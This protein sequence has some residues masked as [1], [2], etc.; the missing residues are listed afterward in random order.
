MGLAVAKDEGR[1]CWACA[2]A[3]KKQGG[4]SLSLKVKEWCQNFNHALDRCLITELTNSYLS[5]AKSFAF[6]GSQFLSDYGADLREEAKT[7]VSY[8]LHMENFPP[9]LKTELTQS[10]TIYTSVPGPSSFPQGAASLYESCPEFC[11]YLIVDMLKATINRTMGNGNEAFDEKVIIFYR[12]VQIFIPRAAEVVYA[13]IRGPDQCWVQRLN[14]SEVQDCIFDVTHDMLLAR[15]KKAA[16]A[17]TVGPGAPV[18]FYLAIDATKVEKVL[19]MSASQRAIIGGTLPNHVFNISDLPKDGVKAVISGTS[20]SV[21]INKAAEVKV[22]VISFQSTAADVPPSF[23]VSGRPQG[24]NETSN[25]VQKLNAA[26]IEVGYNKPSYTN[27][28]VDGASSES[29]NVCGII[30]NFLSGVSGFLGC[31]DTNHNT[32]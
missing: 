10:S 1:K 8:Y 4:S 5:E 25:F 13:N 22:T 20:A 9:K 17:N 27:F 23:I 12:F 2:A 14:N 3:Q 24:T 31:T 26:A 21:K 30:C 18:T 32:K 29:D 11:D 19:D 16:A 7:Q 6:F 28:C 15:T